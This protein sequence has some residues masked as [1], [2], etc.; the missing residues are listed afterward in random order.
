MVKGHEP[1]WFLQKR[2]KKIKAFLSV[3]AREKKNS[4][5]YS[6]KKGTRILLYLPI[7]PPRFTYLK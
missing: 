3:S 7:V 2:I 1:M 4:K 5:D 6:S